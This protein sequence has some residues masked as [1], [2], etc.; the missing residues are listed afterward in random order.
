MIELAGNGCSFFTFLEGDVAQCSLAMTEFRARLP[1]EQHPDAN[2]QFSCIAEATECTPATDCL[3]QF[4]S[5]LDAGS[6]KACGDPDVGTVQLGADEARARHGH[7][8]TK[9]SAA[10]TTK[11]KP[12]EVCGVDGQLEWLVTVTCDDGTQPFTGPGGPGEAMDRAHSARRGS[13]GP[14]GRCQSPIDIYEVTCPERTYEVHMDMY[15]CGPDES[16]D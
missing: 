5:L 14:G 3:K 1:A 10:P 9:F 2:Q 16:F 7:G 6:G 8:A 11:E 4:V 13:V 15:M 12:I